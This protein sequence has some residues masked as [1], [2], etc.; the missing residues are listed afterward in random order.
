M[1][2]PTITTPVINNISHSL[3][4]K[5]YSS[6]TRRITASATAKSFQLSRNLSVSRPAFRAILRTAS[7]RPT[8]STSSASASASYESTSTTTTTTEKNQKQQNQHS[9][10]S[11]EP[12]SSS[13]YI[14]FK[15]YRAVTAD[16]PKAGPL[17]AVRAAYPRD[18]GTE[19]EARK[20]R[21]SE[22]HEL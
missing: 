5:F 12:S 15:E 3:M 9:S 1:P 10:S 16:N 8:S 22:V 4:L 11:N 17:A 6:F 18:L 19:R 20:K 2:L 13:P 7:S 14:S 21:E